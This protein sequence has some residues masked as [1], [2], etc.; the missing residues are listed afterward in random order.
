MGYQG[1]TEAAGSHRLAFPRLQV[2][3]TLEVAGAK[4][5]VRGLAWMNHESSSSQLATNQVG[6]DWMSIQLH[7]GREVGVAFVE[8]TGYAENLAG[9]L[10]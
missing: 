1:A 4:R 5:A 9:R 10:R 3:G 7:D 8:L 2:E 6:W